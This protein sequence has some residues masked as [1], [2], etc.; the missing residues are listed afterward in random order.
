LAS[1]GK[2]LFYALLLF[3]IFVNMQSNLCLLYINKIKPSYFQL[4]SIPDQ[5]VE[6]DTMNAW[7]SGCNFFTILTSS[8]PDT[9]L[10]KLRTFR[11]G[12]YL[13]GFEIMAIQNLREN[14]RYKFLVY[15]EARWQ[16]D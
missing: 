14:S 15:M 8:E 3:A 13:W 7:V 5:I 6:Y 10:E 2:P 4:I 11:D 12:S 16:A 9:L 1:Q